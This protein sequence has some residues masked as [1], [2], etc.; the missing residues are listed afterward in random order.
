MIDIG[1]P[2]HY[3]FYMKTSLACQPQTGLGGGMIFFIII[4]CFSAVY[5]LGGMAY[6]QIRQGQPKHPH[7]QFWCQTLPS[8]VLGSIDSWSASRSSTSGG[9]GTYQSSFQAS[10]GKSAARDWEVGEDAVNVPLTSSPGY[11]SI[12]PPSMMVSTSAESPP[13]ISTDL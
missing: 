5:T 1:N 2:C 11:G 8:I 6:S 9:E 4:L 12:S 3:Q 10:P 13:P 7:H